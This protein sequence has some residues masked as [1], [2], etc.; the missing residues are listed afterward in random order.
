M[1]QTASVKGTASFMGKAKFDQFGKYSSYPSGGGFQ[2]YEIKQDSTFTYEWDDV[3]IA[4]YVKGK[5]RIHLDTIN[6][7]G[8]KDSL[9]KEKIKSLTDI[10]DTKILIYSEG[11]YTL[12][13]KRTYIRIFNSFIETHKKRNPTY[14]K[15]KKLNK[16][17]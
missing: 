8:S 4:A 10:I 6:L 13:R 7:I 12:E 5:W 9:S 11:L 17:S 3:C 1:K 16:E 14:I 2:K 15:D